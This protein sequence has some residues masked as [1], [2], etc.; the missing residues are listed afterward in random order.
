MMNLGIL[1][2]DGHTGKMVEVHLLYL[3]L[4][5]GILKSNEFDNKGSNAVSQNPYPIFKFSNPQL[6]TGV[7][8]DTLKISKVPII[9]ND[10]SYRVL[11]STPAYKCDTLVTSSCSKVDVEAMS[12]TDNDGVPDFIDLDSDN[13]GISDIIE[14]CDVDTDSDGIA[15]C[16]DLDSDGDGCNDV[17]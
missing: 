5:I 17:E 6:Y 4:V 16:L 7:N 10:L 14:G 3:L 12:D 2:M 1:I 8:N 15:N 9:F 11:V 13:D